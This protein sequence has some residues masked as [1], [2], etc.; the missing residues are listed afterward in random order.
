MIDIG[1]TPTVRIR[2]C[3]SATGCRK[4]LVREPGIEFQSTRDAL[5]GSSS[6][7]FPISNLPS[8][9]HFVRGPASGEL[10]AVSTGTGQSV[11]QLAGLRWIVSPEST[12]GFRFHFCSRI[13]S[14]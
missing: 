11:A 1:G 7:Y 13:E 14:L 4:R 8:R 6:G 2:L 10:H 9:S 5:H 3:Q 12:S